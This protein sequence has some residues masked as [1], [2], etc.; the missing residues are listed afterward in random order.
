[1]VKERPYDPRVSI[2]S[3]SRSR[4]VHLHGCF[5]FRDIGGYRTD[6]GGSVR[7]GRIYRSGGPL[8]LSASDE[9]AIS[10]LGLSTV[11]DLRTHEE[12]ETRSGFGQVA[13]DATIV[14]LPMTDLLPPEDELA[15]WS[16]PRFVA[17][18][19]RTMLEGAAPML[20]E[21]IA[22]LTDPS[23]YPAL[24][25]C[26]AGKDRTGIFTAVVL[27]LLGVSDEDIVYDYALSRDGMR[28]LLDWLNENAG[29]QREVVRRYA[30][31]IL[32]ADPT[33]MGEFVDQLVDEFGSFAGYAEHLG[34]ASAIPYLRA[35]LI[36][37]R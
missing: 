21:G 26:S 34:V 10:A 9:G 5:N 6:T 29:D 36:A 1:L 32:A 2:D 3:S 20:R 11:L 8:G 4:Q 24:V 16:D 27:G 37:G 33:T 19:Y 14:H 31:A 15:R 35:Q 18:E 13:P 28:R 25:H 17:H 12:V 7:W 22:V 23:A 30:P